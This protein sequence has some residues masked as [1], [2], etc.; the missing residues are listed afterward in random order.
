MP[1]ALEEVAIYAQKLK[2]TADAGSHEWGKMFTLYEG[3][4]AL[5]FD[6]V[7]RFAL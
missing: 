2:D 7:S 1:A 4:V 6:V 5:T 3:A